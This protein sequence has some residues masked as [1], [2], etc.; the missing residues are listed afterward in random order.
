MRRTSSD[1]SAK[2]MNVLYV[3]E[4]CSQLS[5]S[6]ERIKCETSLVASHALH[7]VPKLPL[8]ITYDK[9][10]VAHAVGLLFLLAD[11]LN[12]RFF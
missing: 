9:T 4:V 1:L 10:V 6:A 7:P 3:V 11:D 12:R 2:Y 5:V 8:E